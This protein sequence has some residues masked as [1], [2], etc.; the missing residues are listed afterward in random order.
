MQCKVSSRITPLGLRSMILDTEEA[1]EDREA[2]EEV[3]EDLFVVEGQSSAI[4]MDN[5]VTSHEIV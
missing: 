1:M 2:M 3:E 4:T 5:K